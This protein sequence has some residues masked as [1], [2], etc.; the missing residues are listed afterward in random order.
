MAGY[1]DDTAVFLQSTSEMEAALSIPKEFAVISS[2]KVNVAK[3]VIVPL[4]KPGA[5][6]P[7]AVLGVP[8]LQPG[9]TCYD[10]GLRVGTHDTH[11][12]NW[13]LC[14]EAT[15]ARIALAVAKTHTVRQRVMIAQAIIV[16]KIAFVARHMWPNRGMVKKLHKLTKGFVWGR[17]DGKV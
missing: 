5:E 1:A 11:E 8:V 17:R 7:V 9:A 15:T 14:L 12:E 16:S 2:L 10:L 4:G 6:Q 3:S 13:R